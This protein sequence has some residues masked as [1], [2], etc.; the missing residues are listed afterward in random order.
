MEERIIFTKFVTED[1]IFWLHNNCEFIVLPYTYSISSSGPITF[2][3]AADKPVLASD[4]STLK[5]EV[6]D[7]V[8]GVLFKNCNAQELENG[9]LR[10]IQEPGFLDSMSYNIGTEKNNRTWEEFARQTYSIYKSAVN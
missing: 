10:M 4:V 6:R 2:A 8:N 7:G 1:E 9:I 3:F 5:E